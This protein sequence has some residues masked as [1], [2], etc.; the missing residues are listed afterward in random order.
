MS[1]IAK[2]MDFSATPIRPT[3]SKGVMVIS[4]MPSRRII[5]FLMNRH[6]VGLLGTSVVLLLS[7]IAY[8][9]FFYVF[10]Q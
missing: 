2:A 1:S 4:A 9:K 5:W 10:F 8:D 7:Y 3:T 6:R